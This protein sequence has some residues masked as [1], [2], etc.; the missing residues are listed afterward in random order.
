MNNAE[1][2]VSHSVAE[3][4]AKVGYQVSESN[5]NTSALSDAVSKATSEGL[6]YQ[7]IVDKMARLASTNSLE[8]N[9]KALRGF[10]RQALE[11]LAKG[12]YHR[13]AKAAASAKGIEQALGIANQ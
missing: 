5:T 10:N 8:K 2:E 12:D 1:A 6:D 11:A 9:Q 7:G 4:A 3:E 13:A